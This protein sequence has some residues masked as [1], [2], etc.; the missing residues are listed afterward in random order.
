L[1][2]NGARIPHF[3]SSYY[4]YQ[5][6]T[7]IPRSAALASQISWRADLRAIAICASVLRLLDYSIALLRDAGGT[8]R[9]HAVQA[10]LDLFGSYLDSSR[11][12]CERV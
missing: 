5:Y 4:V 9:H 11:R 3:Y 12:C 7:G 10:A 2:E 1:I 6:A 8:S